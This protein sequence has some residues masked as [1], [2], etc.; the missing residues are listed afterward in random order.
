MNFSLLP[1]NFGIHTFTI[2]YNNLS[3]CEYNRLFKLFMKSISDKSDDYRY[4]ETNMLYNKGYY[5]IYPKLLYI[6]NGS[7]VNHC[8]SIFVNPRS[9]LQ[10]SLCTYEIYGRDNAKII[11]KLVSKI[12]EALKLLSDDYNI[13]D[14]ENASISRVDLCVNYQFEEFYVTGQYLRLAKKSARSKK[15]KSKAL[16]IKSIYDDEGN[17]H[18]FGIDNSNFEL[19]IYDKSFEL[20]R[21]RKI[22]SFN[23]EYGQVLRIEVKMKKRYIKHYTKNISSNIDKLSYLLKNSQDIMINSVCKIFYPGD[24]FIKSFTKD[25]ISESNY[26]SHIKDLMKEII[27]GDE[28]IDEIYQSIEREYSLSKKSI[29]RIK[30]KFSELGINPTRIPKKEASEGEIALFGFASLLSYTN[31]SE[32]TSQNT[33]PDERE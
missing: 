2:T 28:S 9:L 26:Q 23:D 14:F 16:Y 12:D 15:G 5:G 27:S 33:E 25:R 29:Q 8:L 7:Y 11:N 10:S 30:M 1:D 22:Q 31:Y 21:K 6:A 32:Q 3:T 20:Y 13:Y 4:I 18:H 24:Y 17:D 19:T